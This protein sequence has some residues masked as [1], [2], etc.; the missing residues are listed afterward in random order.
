MTVNYATSD[1][2]ATAGADYTTTN[3]TLTFQVGETSKTVSVPLLDDTIEDGGETLTL[4]L[5]NATVAKISDASATGT[6]QNDDTSSLTAT[7][8]EVPSSHDGSSAFNF[9]VQF[10]ENIG[11]SYAVF[12]DNSFTVTNG[13]VTNANRVD[14]A[15]DLWNVTV[16]PSSNAAVTV[17]LTG[18]RTCGT[19]GAV[20]TFGSNPQPLTNSPSLTVN[21][22]ANTAA[23]GSPTISG[24]VQVG[25]TL[26][27]LTSGITD[28]NELNNVSFEYQWIRSGTDIEG[29]T[30][31][32]YKLVDD[33]EGE[34][35]SVRVSFTDDA[36]YSE[37][38]TSVVTAAV[39]ANPNTAATGSPTISGTAQVGQTLTVSTSTIQDSD[40][41]NNVSFEF[42]WIRSGTDI[43]NATESTYEL[44]DAD[45]GQTIAV[46][47]SFTDDEG[48]AES[49]TSTATGTVAGRPLTASF[50]SVPSEHDGSSEFMV[51]LVFSEAPKVS[52]RVLRDDALSTTGGTV[53]KSRRQQTGSNLEWRVYIEPTGNENVTVTLSTS[54]ACGNNGSICTADGRSLSNTPSSTILGPPG[55]SVADARANEGA[56]ASITFDVTLNR[57]ASTTVTVDYATANGT[58]LAGQDYTSTSGS[59]SFAIGETSKTVTVSLLDDDLD[60]GE[61]TFKL[62]LSNASG[63]HISDNEASGTIVNSDP[64]PQAWLVRFGRIATDHVLNAITDRFEDPIGNQDTDADGSFRFKSAGTYTNAFGT[65]TLMETRD[66]SRLG[67]STQEEANYRARL[68]DHPVKIQYAQPPLLS[69][70]LLRGSFRRSVGETGN[71]TQL[72]TWGRVSASRFHGD[73]DGIAVDADVVTYMLSADAQLG[74]WLTGI[75]LARSL[76]AGSYRGTT[77]LGD[78]D[79]MLTALHPYVLYDLNEQFSAWGVLGYGSGEL[80]IT[81]DRTDH[82]QTDTS[83]HM[84]AAGVR[85]VFMRSED[86][87]ELAARADVRLASISSEEVL[88]RHGNLMSTT[89]KTNRIRALLEGSRPFALSQNRVFTPRIEIGLRRDGGDAESGTGVEIGSVL[90]Y[91]DMARGI[92]VETTARMLLTH[93]HD[94]YR[95]WGASVLVRLDPGKQGRGLTFALTP[96]W[97][98]EM[99]GGVDRL[100]AS[101]DLQRFASEF[102][103]DRG[104]RYLADVGYGLPA[105]RSRGAMT[106]YAGF[107]LSELGRD[108]RTG[109]RWSLDE[110]LQLGLEATLRES[111]YNIR[112][113]ALLR[114]SWHF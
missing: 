60:E 28:A 20:C 78:L 23:T 72:T 87:L 25:Q 63:A 91:A 51:S 2:T 57:A 42:Q 30:A 10:S 108:W 82:W 21:G 66:A 9:Q 114:G 112:S 62:Q 17:V 109:V 100:W 102:G 14:G 89:G 90:A 34:T 61:E 6:I 36:G 68:A 48:N 110:R 26:T 56:G 8:A 13:S 52:F 107:E 86:G 55:L 67:E 33:D 47:V 106:P 44:V 83:M 46:R 69:D 31:S 50:T 71:G 19:T 95:E 111:P 22:P 103:K 49:L 43:E 75:T 54:V 98:V 45:K 65:T 84:G 39:A 99:A 59:L 104:I 24:T 105:F 18:N 113:S 80:S 94:A 76:G 101:R 4:T 29:A 11:I 85:G 16:Q 15:R 40:G 37:S 35:I 58:A 1:V 88:S 27:A 97:G 41:L 32:T 79:T 73:T 92:R 5:S 81:T 93:E 38:L 96:S 3:G 7:F 74:H 53:T 64:L 77:G 70:L 12:R